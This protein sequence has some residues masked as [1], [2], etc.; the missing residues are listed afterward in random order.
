MKFV[1]SAASFTAIG[2]QMGHWFADWYVFANSNGQVN[3]HDVGRMGSADLHWVSWMHLNGA[4]AGLLVGIII[5][6][7]A[8]RLERVPKK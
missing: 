8:M 1:I 6:L 7:I 3:S 5:G 4:F 2:A